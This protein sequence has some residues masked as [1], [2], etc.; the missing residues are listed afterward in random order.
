M[1]KYAS[2]LFFLLTISV[3][4]AAGVS[5]DLGAL[6]AVSPPVYLEKGSQVSLSVSGTWAGTV[7]MQR[8]LNDAQEY[9]GPNDSGWK[10][11]TS[12]SYSVNT[13]ID[14]NPV[15][16]GCW[17]RAKMTTYTSGTATVTLKAE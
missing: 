5:S 7:T 14:S 17:V 16:S 12:S 11:L 4:H 15:A 3:A 8:N 1:T 2:I 13:E 10:D 6:N 9:P